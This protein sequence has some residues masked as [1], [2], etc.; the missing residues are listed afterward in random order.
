MLTGHLA[1]A[2]TV[3]HKVFS[4]NCKEIN[5]DYTECIIHFYLLFFL[6]FFIVPFI[7][8]LFIYNMRKGKELKALF[9]FCILLGIYITMG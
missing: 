5:M 4:Q 3:F 2:I 6:L 9:Y 8:V 7:L 1:H